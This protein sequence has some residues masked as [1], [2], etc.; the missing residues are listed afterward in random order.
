MR[1]EFASAGRIVVGIGAAADLPALALGSGT[2]ALLVTGA[3]MQARGGIAAQRAAELQ[4]A[5]FVGARWAVAGEPTVAD[6]EAGAVQARQ[7]GCDFIIGIGGG[8]VLDTAKAIAA[9]A[10]NPGGAHDYMEVV[11]AGR[12]LEQAAL[13]VVAV[14]TTAGTGSEVTRNAVIADPDQQAKASIRHASMLPRLALVDPE[15]TLDMPPSMTAF[16]GL[17]ALTQLIEPY[18]SVRAQPISDGLC[19]EGL[20]RIIWAMPRSYFQPSDISAREAMSTAS[21]LSGLALA[22]SGLGAVHGI[23]APLGGSYQAPHGAICA[24]LLPHIVATNIAALRRRDPLGPGLTRYARVAEALLGRRGL[25][26]NTLLTDLVTMLRDL[27]GYLNVP[28]LAQYGVTEDAIPALAGRSLQ[29]GSMRANPIVLT[30][31]EV[32]D[33]IHAAL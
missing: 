22:N 13:P 23:A 7:S 5:G 16:S 11:G 6:V 29:A 27:V 19:L 1:Y 28:G 32:E 9:L 33:A 26:D 17:D 8:S 21:L 25:G 20:T 2:R 15:L 10:T 4:A 12:A 30:Q 18:V 3:G 31:A 14:P 24:A